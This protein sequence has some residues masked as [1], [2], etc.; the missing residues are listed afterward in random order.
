MF[1]NNNS[2]IYTDKDK[3]AKNYMLLTSVWTMDTSDNYIDQ[4]GAYKNGFE[5]GE[6][7]RIF[8]ALK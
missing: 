5:S 2:R 8:C 3:N 7:G 4:S 6:S 1:T